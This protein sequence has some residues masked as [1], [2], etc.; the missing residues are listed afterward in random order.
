MKITLTTDYETTD[1]VSISM[2]EQHL[3]LSAGFNTPVITSKLNAARK[4][5]ETRAD[6]SILNQVWTM[7]LDGFP[8]D[9]II[10]PKGFLQSVSSVK[11]YSSGVLTTLIADTDYRVLANMM[12]GIIEPV[13]SWPSADERR[14]AVEIIFTAGH[15]ANPTSATKWAEEAT[16]MRLEML[17]E[18]LSEWTMDDFEA[19]IYQ[20]KVYYDY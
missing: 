11:Y 3:K 6:R 2:A 19:L 14:N 4:D 16:L 18:P 17:Y 13:S 15:G 8:D 12:G 10:L 20:N 9:D 7:Y 1:L 5:V